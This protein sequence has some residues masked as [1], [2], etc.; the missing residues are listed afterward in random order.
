MGYGWTTIGGAP[1]QDGLVK[2]LHLVQVCHII[3]AIFYVNCLSEV[4]EMSWLTRYIGVSPGI[5]DLDYLQG[6]RCYKLLVT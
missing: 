1:R 4:N 6:L 3:C 2:T 5:T